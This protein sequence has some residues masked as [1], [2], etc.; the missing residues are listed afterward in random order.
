MAQVSVLCSIDEIQEAKALV[1]KFS[2]QAPNSMLL[3]DYNAK[4]LRLVDPIVAEKHAYFTVSFKLP[5]LC[6]SLTAD[7]KCGIRAVTK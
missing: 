7:M 4:L 6:P 3:D 2:A 1:L 5:L